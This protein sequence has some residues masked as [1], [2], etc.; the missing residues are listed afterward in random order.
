MPAAKDTASAFT[1]TALPPPVKFASDGIGIDIVVLP[2]EDV[3][4]KVGAAVVAWAATA[5]VVIVLIHQLCVVQDDVPVG[6]DA[7]VAVAAVIVG[8]V[9]GIHAD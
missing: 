9:D 6:V 1:W 2:D 3:A 5:V 7:G 8:G 4:F